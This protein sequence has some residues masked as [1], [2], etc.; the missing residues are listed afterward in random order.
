MPT[1][2]GASQRWKTPGKS[3]PGGPARIGNCGSTGRRCR[4]GQRST[5]HCSPLS[6]RWSPR[7]PL[8]GFA[9]TVDVSD[10]PA[11]LVVLDQR[12]GVLLVDRQSGAHHFLKVV[13]ALGERLAAHVAD[14]LL[15]RRP[16]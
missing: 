16:G 6:T 11:L 10:K 2:S 8:I 14:S 15:L 3:S 4:R 5:K 13:R 9:H 1:N 12:G 7:V